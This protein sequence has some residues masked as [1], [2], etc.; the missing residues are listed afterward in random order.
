MQLWQ[1]WPLLHM[2]HRRV[3]S[4]EQAGDESP[5]SQPTRECVLDYFTLSRK[6]ALSN[7]IIE[8]FDFYNFNYSQLMTCS[9]NSAV[10]VALTL[11]F[12]Q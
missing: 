5:D 4:E 11:L 8:I 3:S 7:F 6:L 2:C 9:L 10:I 12:P 1:G